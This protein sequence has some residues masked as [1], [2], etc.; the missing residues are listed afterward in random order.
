MPITKDLL[1]EAI[2]LIS[3]VQGIS[4]NPKRLI[5]D[6][7]S[8]AKLY[9]DEVAFM[10]AI[11]ETIQALEFLVSGKKTGHALDQNHQ[12][13]LSLP[14]QSARRNGQKADLR[15][16]YDKDSSPLRIRQFGHRWLPDTFYK[17]LELRKADDK[18]GT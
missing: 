16:A 15:I 9:P 6:V 12:D 11:D 10:T 8:L 2:S 7:V 13:I 5:E 4:M 17:R 18:K 3:S 1:L 14:Y